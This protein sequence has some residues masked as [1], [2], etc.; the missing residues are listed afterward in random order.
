MTEELNPQIREVD[1]GVRSLRKLT[2]YP[3][4]M[5]D[6]KK[7]GSMFQEIIEEYLNQTP[8]GPMN[9]SDLLPFAT[10]VLKLIGENIKELLKLITDLRDRELDTF[11]DEVTNVQMSNI[12]NAVYEENF[13]TPSKNLTGLVETIKQLFPSERQLQPFLSDTDNGTLPTSSPEVTEKEG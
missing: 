13:D 12:I 9:A 10:M 11:F 3:M 2:I 1:Y 7:F 5:A 4:S 8:D 6:Q